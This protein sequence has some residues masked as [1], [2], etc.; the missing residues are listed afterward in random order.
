MQLRPASI[1]KLF[2][3]FVAKDR[4]TLVLERSGYPDLSDLAR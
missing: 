4:Y 2:P 1:A 3:T